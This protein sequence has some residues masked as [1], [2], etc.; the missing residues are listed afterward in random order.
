MYLVPFRAYG[1][2]GG[3][4]WLKVIHFGKIRNRTLLKEFCDSGTK[5]SEFEIRIAIQPIVDSCSKQEI[6]SA[7]LVSE[8]IG[9]AALSP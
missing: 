2:R 5:R 6:G 8:V 7:V 3:A 1:N 9:A 4:T